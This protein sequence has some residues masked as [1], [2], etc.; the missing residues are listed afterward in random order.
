MPSFHLTALHFAC[1]SRNDE[2]VKYLISLPE[3]DKKAKDIS[4]LARMQFFFHFFHQVKINKTQNIHE[5][6]LFIE[7]FYFQHADMATS[8]LLGTSLIC[9]NST[10]QRKTSFF[11]FFTQFF[12]VFWIKFINLICGVSFLS[13][14]ERS[15]M[16]LAYLGAKSLLSF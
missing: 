7:Q 1:D 6:R 15:C 16:K 5:E 2:L 13:F 11:F 4:S 10:F 3:V 8:S 12:F 9:M 14:I